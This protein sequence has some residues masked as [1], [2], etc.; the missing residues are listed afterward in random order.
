MLRVLGISSAQSASAMLSGTNTAPSWI[1][2][3]DRG[4]PLQCMFS[5]NGLAVQQIRAGTKRI[6]AEAANMA[7]ACGSGGW[8][9]LLTPWNDTGASSGALIHFG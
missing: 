8:A 6:A 3:H 7:I 5:G 1:R 4:R 9:H 2:E